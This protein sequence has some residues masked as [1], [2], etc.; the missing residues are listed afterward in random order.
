MNTHILSHLSR[1][2]VI[3]LLT[4][5]LASAE[6]P[7]QLQQIDHSILTS[8]SEQITLKL[9]GSYSPKVFTLKGES[10]RVVFDFAGMTQGRG[11]TNALTVNGPLLKGVRVGMQGDAEPKTRVVFD[12]KTLKGVQYTQH[13]DETTST[14]TVRFTGPEKAEAKP[15]PKEQS[16]EKAKPAQAEKAAQA[17]IAPPATAGEPTPVPEAKGEPSM[18]PPAPPVTAKALE[19][20]PKEKASQPSDQLPKSTTSSEPV[21]VPEA[22]APQ[23]SKQE[24]EKKAPTAADTTAK[25]QEKKP[26][27]PAKKTAE[28]QEP[29]PEVATEPIPEAETVAPP[30]KTDPELESIK[31]DPSS[32]KGEMVMFK[33]S[34][35]F[36]P[37]VHGVEEGIPRVICD[38]NNTKLAGSAKKLIKTEGKFVRSIRTSKTKKPEKVRVVIDLEPNHSYDLQQVF[39]KDDNLFVIIVNTIK[40]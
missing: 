19:P 28:S 15:S 1:S 4:L 24:V 20:P 11:V 9:N 32:P 34:G 16:T 29:P 8:A 17:P 21:K 40:K 10:P 39:F 35:F 23:E 33:L 18:P 13:F 30:V 26:A 36:P 22:A 25:V 12:L 3:L 14:L 31:F 38:F 27:E 2:L 7:P 37:S 6:G 5:G